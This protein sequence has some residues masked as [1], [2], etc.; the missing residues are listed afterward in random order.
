MVPNEAWEQ[1][2]KH[3]DWKRVHKVMAHLD[4]GWNS[5]NGVPSIKELKECAKYLLDEV[6]DN[7]SRMICTGGFCAEQWKDELG[8]VRYR[9]MFKLCDW[10]TE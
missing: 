5:S 2:E 8:I 4:W 6:V 9:L 7:D 3:F 1:I 10:D